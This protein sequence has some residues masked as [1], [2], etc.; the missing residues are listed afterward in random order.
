MF[1]LK[2][3]K[4]NSTGFDIDIELS[5]IL[6]KINRKNPIPQ[7]HINYK[8]RSISDGKKLKTSDGWVIL[9]RIIDMVK[10]F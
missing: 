8:R 4:L 1:D 7:V 3:L 9:K 6:T 10:Y 5:S 2:E